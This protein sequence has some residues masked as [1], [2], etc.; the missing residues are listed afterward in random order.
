MPPSNSR[1]SPRANA[2]SIDSPPVSMILSNAR[3]VL[4]DRLLAGHVRVQEGKISAI[5][6]QAI[7][8]APDETVI[9]LTGQFL[10]PGF[11]DMHIH[12]ARHRDTMEATPEAFDTICE[13]H[14][15][16]GTTALA[17]TTVTATNQDILTVLRA[18]QDY[19]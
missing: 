4:P 1:S 18:A 6:E 13:H 16:G 17:L 5:S 12:G 10:A 7:P 14:A 15:R 3:L 8:A 11:I 9:D 19:R 2:V